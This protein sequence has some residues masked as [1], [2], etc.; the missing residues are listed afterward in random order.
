[1]SALLG[2]I[3]NGWSDDF[4]TEISDYDIFVC[5]DVNVAIL[6]E[7]MRRLTYTSTIGYTFSVIGWHKFIWAIVTLKLIPND[8]SFLKP[9]S[10]I[11]RDLKI[12]SGI[13]QLKGVFVTTCLFKFLLIIYNFDQTTKVFSL[14]RRANLKSNWKA[15]DKLVIVLIDRRYLQLNIR[16]YTFYNLVFTTIIHEE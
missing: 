8:R 6:D 7:H 13:W 16:I 4:E 3:L 5:K 1:V 2:Y 10:V 14:S 12:V 15:L 11:D 9:F